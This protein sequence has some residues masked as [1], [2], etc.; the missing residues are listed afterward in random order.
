ME[1]S[2]RFFTEYLLAGI[3]LRMRVDGEQP[4][5]ERI[6]LDL[7][8][9]VHCGHELAVDIG[10]AH[11]V[12]IDNGQ[13]ADT[14]AHNT[15]CTPRAHTTYTEND[16]SHLRHSL[17]NLCPEQQLRTVEYSFF[18]THEFFIFLLI[19]YHKSE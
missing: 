6:H 1:T 4:L 19:P 9:S 8:H 13:M 2:S 17:H 15:L 14:R 10:D 7:P 11:P 18:Y 16:D 12:A 5:F 3:Y